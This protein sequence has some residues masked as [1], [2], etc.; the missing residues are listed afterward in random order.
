MYG[1]GP[2]AN[3]FPHNPWTKFYRHQGFKFSIRTQSLFFSMQTRLLGG[4]STV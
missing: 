3:P 1:S 4:S 2:V